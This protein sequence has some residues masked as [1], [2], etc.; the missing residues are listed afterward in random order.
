MRPVLASVLCAWVL[1]SEVPPGSGRWQ[2][3]EGLQVA[4]ERKAECERAVSDL[5]D[6]RALSADEAATKG[7]PVPPAFWVCLPESI[8]PRGPTAGGSSR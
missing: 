8:D 4:F 6:A 1:W 5:H 3:A 2:L 7:H